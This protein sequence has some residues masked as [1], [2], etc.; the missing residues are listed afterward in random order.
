MEN[1][2]ITVVFDIDDTIC[3]NNGRDYANAIPK[4]DVIAK[5][6]H[7]HD[8]LGY[9]ISLYTSRGMV[10]CEGDV[11]Q[12]IS[13][14]KVVLQNW[15]EKHDVPYDALTFG[16]PLGDLYVD[17]KCIDVYEFLQQDFGPLYG[18][19]GSDVHRVG[20]LVKKYF[21][22]PGQTKAFKL[23]MARAEGSVNVPRVISYLYDSVMLEYIQGDTM[24][25]VCNAFDVMEMVSIIESMSSVDNV[26][27]TFNVGELMVKTANNVADGVL[28]ER[29]G[30]LLEL[31]RADWFKKELRNNVSFCHGDFT[32]SNMIKRDGKIVLLDALYNEEA[33]SV[34]L[35]YAKLRNSFMDYELRFGLGTKSNKCLLPLYDYILRTERGVNMDVILVLQYM[36]IVRMY[37]YKSEEQKPIVIEMLKEMEE[38]NEHL[39]Q[40]C[41]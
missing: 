10:S 41:S 7:L 25:E 39:F 22:G 37:R 33:S 8:D 16:K 24:S 32:M 19:S 29:V 21:N 11:A 20:K 5:I 15:L 13:K 34:L 9:S 36:H 3:D 28:C 6:R 30:M 23:W 4:L 2:R 26:V 17:D 1:K 40:K 35:D 31:M 27:K 14:N 18:G 12:I 38:Q